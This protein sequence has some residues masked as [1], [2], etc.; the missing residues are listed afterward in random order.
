V[1]HELSHIQNRDILFM[2]L[3]S[4]MVGTIAV[5]SETFLRMFIYAPKGGSRRSRSSSSKNSGG[6]AIIV[7]IIVIT[8]IFA[9]LAPI[10]SRIIYF[11]ASRRREYLADACAAQKTRYPEGLASALELIDKESAALSVARKATAPLYIANPLGK[12]ELRALGATHPPTEERIRILRSMGGTVSYGAYQNAWEQVA[13]DQAERIPASAFAEDQE[14]PVRE[15]SAPPETPTQKKNDVRQV[16]DALRKAEGFMFLA[17][18][19][20][21]RIK[22]PPEFKKDHIACPRC[23][24]DVAVPVAQ[25]ATLETLTGTLEGLS[26]QQAQNEKTSP[27]PLPGKEKQP[28]LEVKRS[29]A[30]WFTL[31]CSCGATRSLSPQFKLSTT[32]CKKC[33]RQINIT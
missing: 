32:N 17:C 33:G 4:V 23:S 2:T 8:V 27:P 30:G 26:K 11:A 9:I 24:R 5:L 25:L 28:P 13:G 18:A 10:L 6:G 22:L 31:K 29:G 15:A 20:G 3:L 1:A 21:M 16:T 7:V 19:C 14:V 12:K